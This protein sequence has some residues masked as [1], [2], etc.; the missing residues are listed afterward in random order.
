MINPTLKSQIFFHSLSEYP[1]EC[2]G[3]IVKNG[4][5]KTF[6]CKNISENRLNHFSIGSLDYV[7][8]SKLGQIEAVYHSQHGNRPSELDILNCKGHNIYSIIYLSDYDE[9]LFLDPKTYQTSLTKYIGR[10]F[11]IGKTDCFGLVRDYYKNELGISI[12]NY[13]RSDQIL[14]NDIDLIEKNYEKEGFRKLAPNEELK[15][16]DIILF[17]FKGRYSHHCSIYLGNDTILHHCPV[18]L[19]TVEPL[20]KQLKQRISFVARYG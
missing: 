1:N 8:A 16:N 15:L 2:C 7:R 12:N 6:P 3:L 13:D 10:E 9:F 4:E 20:S 17:R 18:R 11:Y 19:S 5:L 14:K